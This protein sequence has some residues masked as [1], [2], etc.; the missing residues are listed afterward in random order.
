MLAENSQAADGS[1]TGASASSTDVPRTA[2]PEGLQEVRVHTCMA[3][4]SLG[5]PVDLTALVKAIPN[6]IFYGEK[7]SR[8]ATIR[9][10]YFPRYV[11]TINKCGKVYVFTTYDGEEAKRSAKRAARLVQRLYSSAV[12]FRSYKVNNLIVTAK[13]GCGIDIESFGTD[14]NSSSQARDQEP[15]WYLREVSAR[16]VLVD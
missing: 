16:R 8:F 4:F 15:Q 13:T 6:S 2:V 9:A 12:T 1:I 7:T 11:V 3:T 10:N 14:L 5:I